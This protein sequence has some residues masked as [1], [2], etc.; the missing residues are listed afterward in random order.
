MLQPLRPATAANN[1]FNITLN[2]N[3]VAGGF[4]LIAVLA[5]QIALSG[6]T[7]ERPPMT[8]SVERE[9]RVRVAARL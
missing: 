1:T 9:P 8:E 2:R 4:T 5:K 7:P 3:H 6:L